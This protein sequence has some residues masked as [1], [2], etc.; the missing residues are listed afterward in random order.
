MLLNNFNFLGLRCIRRFIIFIYNADV[1]RMGLLVTHDSIFSISLVEFGLN[2][3]ASLFRASPCCNKRRLLL[4]VLQFLN[5]S[6][7]FEYLHVI[8]LLLGIQ[9]LG[10]DVARL[11]NLP[12]H[13][14]ILSLQVLDAAF[15]DRLLLLLTL[16]LTSSFLERRSAN[17]RDNSL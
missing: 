16:Y 4:N 10:H 11:L 3:N 9:L 17:F 7:L 2:T 14:F 1:G 6:L 15:N 13:V 12:L 5:I 8:T